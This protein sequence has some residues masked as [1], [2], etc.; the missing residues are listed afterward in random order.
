MN[1]T[2]S[3][4]SDEEIWS[5]FLTGDSAALD[6]IVKKHYNLLYNYGRKFTQDTDLVKDCIQELFLALWKN[7][8]GTGNTACVKYYL[9]KSLR[10]RLAR[11]LSKTGNITPESLEFLQL[12]MQLPQSPEVQ[13]IQEERHAELSARVVQAISAL[14][15]RQQEII[16]LRFY[17][18]ANAAEI[19]LIM[20][21]SRQ[22]V[23]NLLQLA[24][25]RLRE[26]SDTVFKH[27]IGYLLL[28][29]ALFY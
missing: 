20:N 3:G 11:E 18:N 8:A 22:S 24:I 19:G 6:C 23:Y 27:D 7:R 25:S 26:I 13:K 28:L 5:V 15:K 21:L 14:S 17:L 4:Y 12:N 29:L 16:Y 2:F 9:M 10:R 1:Q